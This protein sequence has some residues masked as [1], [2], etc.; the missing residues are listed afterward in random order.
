MSDTPSNPSDS[1]DGRVVDPHGHAVAGAQ[2][3]V[4]DV[5]SYRAL[6]WSTSDERGQFEFP[7]SIR[8]PAL[9]SAVARGYTAASVEL[10]EVPS[11]VVLELAAVRAGK[12]YAGKV[13]DTRG[14]GL[15]DVRVRLM[16]WSSPTGRAYY[17][18]TSRD[19]S[20]LAEVPSGSYD[21]MVD[22]PTH[23]SDFADTSDEQRIRLLAHERS[24][25]ERTPHL[26]VAPGVC[27]PIGSLTLAKFASSLAN[28]SV[29][30]LGES[31]HGTKE[32]TTWRAE[33]ISHLARS[34][35]LAFVAMEAGWH[36]AKALDDYASHGVGSARAAV[37]QLDYWPW[38]TE[39]M[40]AFVERVRAHNVQFPSQPVRFIGVDV[41]Y[42]QETLAVLSREFH[43]LGLPA[44][45]L[46]LL[47]PLQRIRH[48][49]DLATLSD[50]EI[51][52]MI[53]GIERLEALLR[54]GPDHR[55]SVVTSHVSL[56]LRIT[57]HTLVAARKMPF[58]MARNKI[59]ADGAL[60]VLAAGRGKIAFWGHSLHIARAPIEGA[61]PAGKYLADAL[62]DGYHALGTLFYQGGFHAFSPGAK[63]LVVHNTPPPPKYFLE[64]WLHS[65]SDNAACIVDLT[66][67]SESEAVREWLR[68]PRISRIYGSLEISEDY[69]WPP[70][71]AD[72]LWSSILFV[73]VSTPTALLQD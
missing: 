11:E 58:S 42:P 48:W 35:G 8:V 50:H 40:V 6:H 1:F 19:G 39:E 27:A 12:V 41:T 70:V 37:L 45:Y 57:R 2:V 4:V 49:R 63:S 44:A 51:D 69:P 60:E 47:S 20:F 55:H 9:I 15:S 64:A 54:L 28:V 36:D 62:G 46:H 68:A 16:H 21:V 26:G 67:L 38:R 18:A 59:M 17:T 32:Y 71:E 14:T 25:V 66:K 13:V 30:G 3:V 56:G 29:I 43:G 22:D 34:G 7:K 24:A 52:T 72:R 61:V 65:A 73:P 31:T 23:V 53:G 10:S 33:I 5:S